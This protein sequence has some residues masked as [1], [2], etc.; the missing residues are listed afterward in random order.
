ML[1]QFLAEAEEPAAVLV[2]D[3]FGFDGRNDFGTQFGED[4]LQQPA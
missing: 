3:H 4:W 2:H 1:S